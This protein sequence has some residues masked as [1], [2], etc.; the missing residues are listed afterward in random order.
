MMRLTAKYAD[1]WNVWF[2]E[3]DNKVENLVEML[4]R[5][6][7]AC[8]KV[9]RDPATL[10]RSAA[11]KIEVGKHAPSTMSTDPI[12]GSPVEIA[13][14]LRAYAAVGLSH[15]Q[16]WPEPCTVQGVEKFGEIFDVLDRG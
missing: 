10:Q 12:S 15:V 6:D 5:L 7:E 4:K 16:V 8:F 2:K 9:G 11:V 14:A 13:A 1:G 3:I